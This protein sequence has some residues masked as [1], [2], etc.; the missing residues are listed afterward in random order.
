MW[1]PISLI[2]LS[3]GVALA[4]GSHILELRYI[5]MTVLTLFTL[6]MLRLL[7]AG[8][9]FCGSTVEIISFES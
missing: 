5:G 1:K 3:A 4:Q 9:V 8:C 7:T 6:G 2:H